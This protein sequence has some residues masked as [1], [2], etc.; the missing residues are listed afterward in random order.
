ML[1]FI[2]FKHF[3]AAGLDYC[4]LQKK[5]LVNAEQYS[6][7]DVSIPARGK[8]I[9]KTD[10]S[11]AVPPDCYGRIGKRLDNIYCYCFGLVTSHYIHA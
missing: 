7:Y 4:F 9:V 10:L 5:F 2:S 6:A 1:Y 11:I 8:A 3:Q